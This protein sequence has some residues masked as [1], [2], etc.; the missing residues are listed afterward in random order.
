MDEHK[1]DIGRFMVAVG[2]VIECV[3]DGTILVVKRSTNQDFQG[4]VWELVYGRVS[5]FEAPIDGLI[6]EHR[7]EVGFDSFIVIRPLR[8][9]H[10]Y[11]G[12][13]TAEKEL[14]GITYWCQVQDKPPIHLNEEHT[15]YAWVTPEQ[16]LEL[17]SVEGIKEDVLTYIKVKKEEHARH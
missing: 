15:E 2:A 8:T 14:I 12:E 17:I 9:W 4:G 5:Q 13:E 11:R 6:R 1:N 7:E 16:A 3:T 10:L